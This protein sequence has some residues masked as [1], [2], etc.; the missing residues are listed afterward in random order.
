MSKSDLTI[1]GKLVQ[2]PHYPLAKPLSRYSES[3][4]A[5]R[6]GIQMTD[7]DDPPKVI[8]LTSTVP[9]EGKTTLAMCLAASAAVSGLKVLLVDA[10]LRHPSVSRFFGAIKNAGLV[11]L[12]LENAKLQDVIKY[13][14]EVQY[15]VLSAGG[16]C[17]NPSDL[18]ASAR[19]KSLIASA[20]SSFDLVIIDTPPV[21]PVIDPV[22]VS[23]LADKVVY[24]VRWATTAREMVKRTIEQFSG[25]KKVAGV[26]FNLV[27]EKEAQKYGKH[28]YGYYYG[29]RSSFGKYY[30]G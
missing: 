10:D 23:Q 28:A 20:K 21:G 25:H 9:G 8:Q 2:L 5:L 3:L 30:E 6:S 11:E 26:V 15:W 12:L 18:L 7:V 14:E 1:S 17:Q 19:M 4:R 27:N 16:K 24:V 22:I 29:S 13:R